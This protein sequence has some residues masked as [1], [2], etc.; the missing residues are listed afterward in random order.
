MNATAAQAHVGCLF[1][2]GLIGVIDVGSNSIRLVVFEDGVRSPDY[3]F[4]EKTICRLGEG[5]ADTG[6]L[7][8]E[9]RIRAAHALRRFTGLT[10]R[11]GVTKLFAVGTAALR[12]AEDGPEFREQIL[13][14]TGVEIR[15]ASGREEAQLAAQG[16]LLG[17][18]SVEGVI[19][20]IGGSSLELAHISN[21]EVLSAVSTPAGHLRMGD[22]SE[23]RGESETARSALHALDSAAAAFAHVS[24]DL[25]LVGGAWRGLA[26]AQME[27]TNYPLHVLQGYELSVAEADDLCEWAVKAN[28]AELKK[29]SGSSSARASSLANGAI[30]LQRLLRTLKPD[31]VTISAFGLREGLIYE[32]MPPGMRR[33]DPLIAVA[34]ATEDRS[35]RYPGFGEELFE[36]IR[37]LLGVVPGLSERLTRAACL[38]HDVNWRAHPDFRAAACFATV[39]R[40]NLSGV[41]HSHRL[42]LGAALVHRYKGALTDVAA[43]AAVRTL[44]EDAARGA[45]VVGRG[46]RLGAMITGSV[47]GMLASTRLSVTEE[48]LILSVPPDVGALLGER[49]ERR[50]IALANALGRTGRIE[51]IG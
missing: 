17:W 24:G 7:S 30:A 2:R 26:K 47:S 39:A 1:G 12:E 3:V 9:G 43:K 5:L 6:K 16:V 15:V 37:P 18:P 4:N 29:L 36:W 33:L 48:D 23:S 44:S 38:L 45:E 35:A 8:P 21:G 46:L 28:P 14:E 40:A 42:F 32:Q 13:A 19:A 22:S 50:F 31:T 51:P 34:K 20:D 27:R 25:V 41:S 11:M 10:K 49:V